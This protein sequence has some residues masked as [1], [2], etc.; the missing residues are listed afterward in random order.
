MIDEQSLRIDISIKPS[1]R[2]KAG[3]YISL[4][5]TLILLAW[6]AQLLLWQY[7]LILVVSVMVVI[8]LALS[9][10][11]I[12]HVSQPPLT[13][14]L[15]QNWQVLVRTAR[16]DALW[17]VRLL[18]VHRYHLCVHFEFMVVE[19]H[20]RSLSLTVFRDQVSAHEWQMMNV[21]ANVMRLAT[22]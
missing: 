5:S 20:Q 22:K 12:L 2:L 13:Q 7:V 17:Q 15:D 6:L 11:I 3:L 8:Y 9:R 4:I 1:S 18:S 14:R 21:L 10:P 19:P 16:G